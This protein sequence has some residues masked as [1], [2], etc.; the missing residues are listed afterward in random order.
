MS[1]RIATGY[2][3]SQTHGSPVLVTRNTPRASEI[4]ATAEGNEEKVEGT[5]VVEEKSKRRNQP[6]KG[7]QNNLAPQSH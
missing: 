7:Y 6:D 4:A 3:V 1:R 2:G 5:M